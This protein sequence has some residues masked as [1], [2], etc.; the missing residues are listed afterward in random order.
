MTAPTVALRG[1]TQRFGPN[2]ALQVS[3]LTLGPGSTAVLGANGS[4]KSTLCCLVATVAT[5][6]TGS[7]RVGGLDPRDPDQRIAIRRRLGYQTQSGAL[8]ARMRVDTFYD[9]VGALK[10]ITDSRARRRWTHWALDGMGPEGATPVEPSVQD[11]YT[12][13][14]GRAE[15][16]FP[17]ISRQGSVGRPR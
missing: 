8:P 1:L 10:E 14:V 17:G 3:E 2:V 12:V 13:V 7:V 16:Q 4:G 9:Y 6:E 11:G 5:P 15:A